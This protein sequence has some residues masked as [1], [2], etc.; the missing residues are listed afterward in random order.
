[1]ALGADRGSV[2]GMVIRSG[3]KLVGARRL[4]HARDIHLGFHRLI[5]PCGGE[6]AFH[7]VAVQHQFASVHGYAIFGLNL[8]GNLVALDLAHA[9]RPLLAFVR[10]GRSRDGRSVLLQNQQRGLGVAIFRSETPR[11]LPGGIGRQRNRGGHNRQKKAYERSLHESLQESRDATGRQ[12]FSLLCRP[13]WRQ[14]PRARRARLAYVDWMDVI[15]STNPGTARKARSATAT[16]WLMV[17]PESWG[18][19]ADWNRT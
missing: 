15:S 6:V 18:C 14:S 17:E 11:P 2:L 1:M 9:Y 7:V 16:R 5:A 8:H 4:L 10:S 12:K 19:W 13:L 3:L